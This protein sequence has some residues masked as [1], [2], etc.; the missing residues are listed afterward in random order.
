LLVARCLL[1]FAAR[2]EPRIRISSSNTEQS[3]KLSCFV[4]R[5]LH[6]LENLDVFKNVHIV[7]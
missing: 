3:G 4:P 6:D 1:W 5:T 2:P 7:E